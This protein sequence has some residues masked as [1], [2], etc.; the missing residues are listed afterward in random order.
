MKKGSSISEAN[1]ANF[2]MVGEHHAIGNDHA[3]FLS[4]NKDGIS[5]GEML[6]M[7]PHIPTRFLQNYVH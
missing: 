6:Q 7:T 1:V 3:G 2:S 5:G 4:G